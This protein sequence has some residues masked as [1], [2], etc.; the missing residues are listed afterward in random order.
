[1]KIDIKRVFTPDPLKPNLERVVIDVEGAKPGFIEALDALIDEI[2]KD[3]ADGK[4]NWVEGLT[5]GGKVYG[6]VV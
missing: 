5:I 4:I 6:L 2:S 3:L 1:M